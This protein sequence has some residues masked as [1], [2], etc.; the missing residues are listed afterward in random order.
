MT[1]R[2]TDLSAAVAA[3]EHMPAKRRRT[4]HSAAALVLT[5]IANPPAAFAHTAQLSTATP[6]PAVAATDANDV[7]TWPF[8]VGTVAAVAV[9][10][11]WAVRRGR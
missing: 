4:A 11:L 1:N 3:A 9:A 2:L 6:A 8:V 10:A 7:P 5:T